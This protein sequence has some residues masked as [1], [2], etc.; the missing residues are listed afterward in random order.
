[1]TCVG[2]HYRHPVARQNYAPRTTARLDNIALDNIDVDGRDSNRLDALLRLATQGDSN[3]Q[4]LVD[5]RYA[6]IGRGEQNDAEV[7]RW[8]TR[9]AE[10][11]H[12]RAQSA[13]ATFYWLGHGTA[14]DGI[15]AYMWAS[16]AQARGDY[17]DADFL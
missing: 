10:N 9:D 15:N 3:A 17:T 2:M 6:T 12:P 4:F 13:L 14:H 1:M 11:G 16:I 7:V 5:T 8:L